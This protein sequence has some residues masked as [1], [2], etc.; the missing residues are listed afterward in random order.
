[1]IFLMLFINNFVSFKK[2]PNDLELVI[3]YQQSQTPN[4]ALF[5]KYLA[6]YYVD[7][8]MHSNLDIQCF[9]KYT[10]LIFIWMQTDDKCIV[11]NAILTITL[12]YKDKQLLFWNKINA[13][14]Y[15]FVK[16][17]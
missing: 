13:S 17:Y 3:I 1:M 4:S 2:W 12:F 10:N 8:S 6:N 9:E 16:I 11:C 15:K 14:A 7:H 5:Q